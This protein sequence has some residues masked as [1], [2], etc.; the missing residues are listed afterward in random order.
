MKKPK[1]SL[2]KNWNS[3]WCVLRKD[4][5]RGGHLILEYYNEHRD[6]PKAKMKGMINTTAN[7]TAFQIISD[8]EINELSANNQIPGDFDLVQRE[9]SKS[10]KLYSFIFATAD[11]DFVFSAVNRESFLQWIWS[12]KSIM[13]SDKAFTQRLRAPQGIFG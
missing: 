2:T 11:R 3:R 12:L 9:E 4:S 1:R 6:E 10:D 7:V 5:T 8:S 13:D